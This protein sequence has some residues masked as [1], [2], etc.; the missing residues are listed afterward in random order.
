MSRI[1]YARS[2]DGTRIGYRTSGAGA[3]LV[4]VH[5]ATA[6]ST[7]MSLLTPLLEQH[8]TVHAMDRRGRGLS[9]DAPTY[10]IVLEYA[11]IAAVVDA[12]ARAAGQTVSL[13]GHSYGAVCALGAALRTSNVERLFLYEPG[14]GAVLSPEPGVLDRVDDLVAAGQDDAAL[15]HFYRAAV[16]MS[17]EDVAAMRSQ[18]SWRARLATVPTISREARVAA[19][20]EFDPAPYRDF[21][22]PSVLLLGEPTGSVGPVQP[23]AEG[24]FSGVRLPRGVGR[25]ARTFDDDAWP[26]SVSQLRSRLKIRYSRRSDTSVIMPRRRRTPIAAAKSS[27]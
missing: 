6:D 26:N 1:S 2:V 12:C 18:P 16:G 20:L 24:C 8:F 25:R 3:P 14:F 17:V 27:G 4:L 13:Y 15:E 9:G 11:D 21:G 19:G 5:G 22:T 7:V 10:D 23:G